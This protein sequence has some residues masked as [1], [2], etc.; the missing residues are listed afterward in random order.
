MGVIGAEDTLMEAVM[1]MGERNP[2]AMTA[3]LTMHKALGEEKGLWL[4]VNLDDIDC[5]G[6]QIHYLYADVCGKDPKKVLT[7]MEAVWD[8]KIS[9]EA[10]LEAADGSRRTKYEDLMKG[11]E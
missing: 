6:A 10:L 1:K 2:G 9:K 8:K 5:H 3:L 11:V 7:L 4:I